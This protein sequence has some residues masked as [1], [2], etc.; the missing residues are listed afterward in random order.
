MKVMITTL[1][2]I[3]DPQDRS[4][5]LESE[6]NLDNKSLEKSLNYQRQ[7]LTVILKAHTSKQSP[8]KRG[9]GRAGQVETLQVSKSGSSLWKCKDG[10]GVLSLSLDALS[11]RGDELL[12]VDCRLELFWD[13]LLHHVVSV[14]SKNGI[15]YAHNS[16]L[17]PRTKLETN[18]Q[19]S[20]RSFRSTW[21]IQFQLQWIPVFLSQR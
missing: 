4:D 10:R 5:C 11:G 16:I 6:R 20:R 7:F 12:A 15:F 21:P 14:L 3:T 1:E 2:L 13:W 17:L 19:E 8:T 18:L 9:A